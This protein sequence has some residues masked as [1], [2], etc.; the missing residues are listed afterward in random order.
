M[1]EPHLYSQVFKDIH[2]HEKIKEFM[3]AVVEDIV[4]NSQ[5]NPSFEDKILIEIKVSKLN[6]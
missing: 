2:S 6:E 3:N 5:A 4:S 1:G